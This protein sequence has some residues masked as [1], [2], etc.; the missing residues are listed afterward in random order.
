MKSFTMASLFTVLVAAAPT[1]VPRQAPAYEIAAQ[2]A[3]DLESR[4]LGLDMTRN[5]LENGQP[6]CPKAIFIFARGSTEPG[7]M[8]ASVGPIVAN[9]LTNQLGKGGIWI[10]GVGGPYTAG[11]AENAMPAGSSPAAIGEMGRLFTLA[12]TKCPS[13]IILAGGYSQG[14]ALAAAAVSAASPAVR[15]QIAA[16]VLFGYTKNLQNNGKIPNYPADRVKVF[17]NP[18]DMVCTGSLFITEAH[19]NY[20]PAA[21]NAAPQFLE[22]KVA[23]AASRHRTSR[24]SNKKGSAAAADP[25]PQDSTTD[26]SAS[27]DS[28]SEAPASEVPTGGAPAVPAVQNMMSSFFPQVPTGGNVPAASNPIAQLL[29]GMAPGV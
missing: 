6:P 5:D 14:A 2:D 29:K 9:T 8:G 25:D 28:T 19:L 20:A 3:K 17:C 13:S 18:G 10:Q 27:Q 16:T 4:Q 24:L 7:N 26:A 21:A 15:N 1:P 22:N 11:L 12:H 23:V